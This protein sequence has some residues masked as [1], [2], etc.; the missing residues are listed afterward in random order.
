MNKIIN[1]KHVV[2]LAM[3]LVFMIACTKE[4]GAVGDYT[5][6]ATIVGQYMYDEGQGDDQTGYARLIKPAVGVKVKVSVTAKDITG[7]TKDTGTVIFETKTNKNGEYKIV[8]PVGDAGLEATIR[9][10][11]FTGKYFYVE[12]INNGTPIYREEEVIYTASSVKIKLTPNDIKVN[13]GMYS[14]SVTSLENGYPYVSLFTVN[15]GKANYD[16]AGTVVKEYAPAT[17]VDVIITVA[18]KD[19]SLKYVATTAK[20]GAA[21]FYIPT[22]DKEWS[23]NISVSAQPFVVKNFTYYTG[24]ERYTIEGGIFQQAG[25]VSQT[26]NFKALEGVPSPECKVK[27]NFTPFDNVEAYGYSVSEWSNVTF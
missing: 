18:Y 21:K 6:N 10:E 14:H 26:F 25:T 22:N 12:G 15:V 27:M 11:D 24:Q 16:K 23:A 7:D 20:D 2:L 1:F 19:K 13:N 4:Q 5:K 3:S 8:V 17:D 9:P